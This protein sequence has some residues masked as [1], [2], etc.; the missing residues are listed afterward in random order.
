MIQKN[1]EKKELFSNYYI[2][3]GDIFNVLI[4]KNY[5]FNFI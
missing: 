5:I 2:L 1:G 3:L 4:V